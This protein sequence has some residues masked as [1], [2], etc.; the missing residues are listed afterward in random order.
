MIGQL[1]L[2][3]KKYVRN[4]SLNELVLNQY[5]FMKL[6]IMETGIVSGLFWVQVIFSEEAVVVQQNINVDK[7][8]RK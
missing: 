2:D 1:K 3:G 5:L 8:E 6:I 4:T 7:G